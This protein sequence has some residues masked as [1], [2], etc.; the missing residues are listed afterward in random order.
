MKLK[1]SLENGLTDLKIPDLKNL[2][3]FYSFL[4][5]IDQG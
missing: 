5:L 1:E 2:A 3:L 4:N